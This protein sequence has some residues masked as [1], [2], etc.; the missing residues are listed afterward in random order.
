MC[1][2]VIALILDMLDEGV[3]GHDETI[4]FRGLL[5]ETSNH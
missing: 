4:V 2:V 1:A 5:Q 3:V